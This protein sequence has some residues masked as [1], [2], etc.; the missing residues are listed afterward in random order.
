[1]NQRLPASF[2]Q[3]R[4]MLEA[5]SRSLDSTAQTGNSNGGD[6][7]EEVYQKVKAM[8]DQYFQGLADLY[9]KILGK[10]QQ[11]VLLLNGSLYLNLVSIESQWLDPFKKAEVCLR[12]KSEQSQKSG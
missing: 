2:H 5:S 1:M 8:K 11:V 4:A 12:I 6:C 3:Q 10:L 9:P 7:Q